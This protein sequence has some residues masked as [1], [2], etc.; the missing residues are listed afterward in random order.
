[1]RWLILGLSALWLGCGA[2]K[3]NA[4]RTPAEARAE[5]DRRG[6]AYTEVV[7]FGAARTGNLAVVRLF[8]QAGMSVNTHHYNW[9]GGTVLHVAAWYG[10]LEVVKYL[11]ESGARVGTWDNGRRTA[12]DLAA[13]AGHFKIVK[14]LAS[15]GG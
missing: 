8:V 13:R 9:G 12:A 4:P 1:M 11:V 3:P 2:D 7:F 5:L 6:I 14:Y 10:H 15:Q